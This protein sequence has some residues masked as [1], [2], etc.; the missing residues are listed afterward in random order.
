MTRLLCF[1]REV[2]NKEAGR[3]TEAEWGKGG[4]RWGT[5]RLT[6]IG[7]RLDAQLRPYLHQ[8]ALLLCLWGIFS[9]EE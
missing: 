1:G 3:E 8:I 6:V 7:R 9:T 5:K 2:D 4:R